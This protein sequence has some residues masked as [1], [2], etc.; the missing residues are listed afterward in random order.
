[1]GKDHCVLSV[2]HRPKTRLAGSVRRVKGMKDAV[3]VPA[4][5][6]T[7][8]AEGFVPVYERVF[9]DTTVT[10]WER[11]QWR[12]SSVVCEVLAR[13]AFGPEASSFLGGVLESG[14]ESLV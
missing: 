11:E 4:P 12:R 9:Q 6:E 10:I 1:M 13:R 8:R 2:R 14:R 3:D 7:L 5:A